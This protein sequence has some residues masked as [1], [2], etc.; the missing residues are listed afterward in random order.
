MISI[1]L[2]AFLSVFIVSLISLVGIIA[3]SI[4][5]NFLNKYLFILVSIAA[6]ALFGDAVI[7]LIPQSFEQMGSPALASFF[8]LVGILAFFILEKFLLW[9]H[10]H[11][12]EYEDELKSGETNHTHPIGPLILISDGIHNLLDGII[13]GA[14]FFISVEVGIATTIAI[15]LHEIPQEIGDFALLIHAGY[16]RMKALLLNFVSG[17]IALLGVVIVLVFTNVS[18]LFVPAMT[19]IAAGSFLYIAGSDLVPE[20]HKTSKTKESLQQLA[21][22]IIGIALMFLLLLLEN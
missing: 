9:R 20:L 22:L 21:A 2:Y 10:T 15:I 8:V 5:K 11:G 18:E 6:G 1:P 16:S 4:Q 14:S 7:H 17:L 12:V 3:L 19:A 13:I